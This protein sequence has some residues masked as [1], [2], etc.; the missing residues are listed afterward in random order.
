M[1]KK[2]AFW[3]GSD[4]AARPEPE[5]LRLLV[6]RRCLPDLR[7]YELKYKNQILR[8]LR[9]RAKPRDYDS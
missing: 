9:R 7:T 8:S 6:G 1:E 3:G 5:A 2:L 4:I